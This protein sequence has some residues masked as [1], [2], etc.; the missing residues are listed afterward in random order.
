MPG[1][2]GLRRSAAAAEELFHFSV[3]PVVKSRH[4]EVVKPAVR[5]AMGGDLVDSELYRE[6]RALQ[7][8]HLVGVTGGDGRDG[9]GDEGEW[10]GSTN[11][12]F[13]AMQKL[14]ASVPHA[15][16]YAAITE[17]PGLPSTSPPLL[18]TRDGDDPLRWGY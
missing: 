15:G 5:A 18:R 1:G 14:A 16:A 2:G 11:A 8:L 7:L 10:G 6:Q 3:E 13:E 17:Y 12:E 9:G 4:L